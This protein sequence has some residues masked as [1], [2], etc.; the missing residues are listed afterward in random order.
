MESPIGINK[1]TIAYWEERE[2]AAK[3][4]GDLRDKN[5]INYLIKALNF[6]AVNEKEYR[7]FTGEH[8]DFAKHTRAEAAI[9]LGKIGGEKA[10]NALN[11][12]ALIEEKTV[13]KLAIIVALGKIG[14]E[15]SVP[16]LLLLSNDSKGKVKRAAKISLEKIKDDNNEVNEKQKQQ[17]QK[18]KKINLWRPLIAIIFLVI[19]YI[20]FFKYRSDTENF[21]N[22]TAEKVIKKLNEHGCNIGL[23]KKTVRI[24]PKEKKEL[25]KKRNLE[26]GKCKEE[27]KP[28]EVMPF[29]SSGKIKYLSKKYQVE[30]FIVQDIF[31]N[32]REE[33]GVLKDGHIVKIFV[34]YNWVEIEQRVIDYKKSLPK[35]KD[36][37]EKEKITTTIFK[38]KAEQ[39]NYQV[40]RAEAE[41]R[42]KRVIEPS[43]PKQSQPKT[44]MDRFKEGLGKEVNKSKKTDMIDVELNKRIK[45]LEEKAKQEGWSFERF[46]TE[47][48]LEVARWQ[49][50]AQRNI[51]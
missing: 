10:I 37:Y 1:F 19:L 24:I 25:E 16:A 18:E 41:A 28:E 33:K 22:A 2:K 6:S 31:D 30:L 27:K 36:E 50:F 11:E 45:V 40:D 3:T 26:K 46:E 7:M 4:L 47:R 23:S 38:E 51:K 20:Y 39:A 13:V 32:W 35:E 17:E 15:N 21:L 44:E 34:Q 29:T 42:A 48:D 14:N 49:Q 5:V 43:Q 9:A 8:P 12:R